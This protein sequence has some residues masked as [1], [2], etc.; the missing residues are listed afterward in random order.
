MEI[1]EF[2][3]L[4]N[5]CRIRFAKAGTCFHICSHENHPVI[6][7]NE[8]E[9]KAAMNIVAFAAF[10]LPNLKIFTF[11]VMDN[12][13]HFTMSG[14]RYEID[15]FL[16]LLVAKMSTIP[17]LSDSR[18]EIKALQFKVFEINS[19]EN[20]RNVISYN[21]R[22]GAVVS[23]NENVF[24]YEWGA[25]RFFF[26]REARLR[27]KGCGRKPLCRERRKLFHSDLL[28]KEDKLIVLDGYVSPLCFCHIAEA[29]SF[30]RSNR[31]YFYSVSRNI[32]AS[33]DIAGTIGES[34]FYTDED[35]FT[36]IKTFCF[37]K[38]ECQS[39]A[40]LPKEAKIELAKDLRFNYNASSKQIGRLLKIDLTVLN[41]LF[42]EKS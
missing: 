34:L 15:S 4:E 9:F 38:Y 41:A 7:H 40:V 10:S 14:K 24:T 16:Q 1:K 23:V 36:Y 3:R 12:H 37:K 25:N 28:S 35:L 2:A 13:F 8:E 18:N 26:N 29:E 20:I 31:H 27:F 39:I 33:K 17:E 11:E 6:F 22:N 5:M 21:N 32:E 42:P 30:F 19:L